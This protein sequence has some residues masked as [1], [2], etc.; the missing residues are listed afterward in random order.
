MKHIIIALILASQS[1]G[2]NTAGLD[3]AKLADVLRLSETELKIENVT[4]RETEARKLPLKSAWIVSAPGHD[5]FFPLLIYTSAK[6]VLNGQKYE[7]LRETLRE[8]PFKEGD[9]GYG[10]GFFDVPGIGE[11]LVFTEQFTISSNRLPSG[12]GVIVPWRPINESGLTINGSSEAANLDFQIALLFLDEDKIGDFPEYKS[13]LYGPD[14][15]DVQKLASALVGVVQASRLLE[16]ADVRPE[17]RPLGGGKDGMTRS[18][19]G[20]GDSLGETNGIGS[21]IGVGSA[22]Q[23]SAIWPWLLGV[24][25]VLVIV[26]LLRR[27]LQR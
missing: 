22:A 20:G 15:P 4:E 13:M 9:F 10:L 19:P 14:F 11:C 12:E 2:Q 23:V 24:I 1:P 5:M 7:V 3:M 26:L 18:H 25:T 27:L 8:K 21:D 17:K 16:A 6:G